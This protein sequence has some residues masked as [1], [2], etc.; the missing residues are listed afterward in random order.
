M[1]T[2]YAILTA[3]LSLWLTGCLV[4][5]KSNVSTPPPPQP[6]AA[7]PAPV[8][9]GAAPPL[10][11][12]QTEVKLTPD[13]PIDQEALTPAPTAAVHPEAPPPTRTP[14]PRPKPATPPANAVET[15]APPP[16][17][18]AAT[19]APEPERERVREVLSPTESKRLKTNADQRKGEVTR[20]LNSSA[21]RRLDPNDPTVARIRSTLQSSDEAE[22]RGDMREASDLADRAMA[23]LRELRNGR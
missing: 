1:K 3:A 23:F 16:P 11:L 17:A 19:V 6:V 20:F 18:A 15:P 4:K 13:Q 12:T 10:S 7:A 8:P 5:G 21:G 2:L 14:R 9:A 22:A